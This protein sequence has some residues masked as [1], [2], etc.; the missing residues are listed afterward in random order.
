LENH[1]GSDIVRNPKVCLLL[2]ISGGWHESGKACTCYPTDHTNKAELCSFVEEAV[3]PLLNIEFPE[4][5]GLVK[6]SDGSLLNGILELLRTARGQRPASGHIADCYR[7]YIF[8]CHIPL[9]S[10]PA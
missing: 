8:C 4:R 2:L 9:F 3:D 1:L 5:V 10:Y 7:E 6:Y